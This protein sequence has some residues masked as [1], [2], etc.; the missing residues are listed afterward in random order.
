MTSRTSVAPIDEF[1]QGSRQ[2]LLHD[3]EGVFV[4]HSDEGLF[5]VQSHCPHAGAPLEKGRIRERA[6]TCPL[7]SWCFD[8]DS[9]LIATSGRGPAL[10]RY[11]VEI[12]DGEVCI[13]SAI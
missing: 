3:G 13:G 7:H 11:L 8:L 4:F 5:A 10:K 9:G 2:T 6:L 1:P 12:V